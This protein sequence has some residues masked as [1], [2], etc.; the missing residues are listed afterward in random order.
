MNTNDYNGKPEIKSIPSAI[1]IAFE[2]NTQEW[3]SY[4]MT[5]DKNSNDVQELESQGYKALF[6]A[7]LSE[8]TIDSMSPEEKEKYKNNI[9]RAL[10]L[11][12]KDTCHS[13]EAIRAITTHYYSSCDGIITGIDYETNSLA[14]FPYGKI[15]ESCHQE[16]YNILI[17]LG[18]TAS[19]NG[20]QI[21]VESKTPCPCI[22]K[23]KFNQ[24]YE[25]FKDKAILAAQNIGLLRDTNTQARNNHSL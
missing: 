15:P 17:E 11:D 3:S 16:L 5:L 20:L 22:K 21:S 12:T 13:L 1:E 14:I 9:N 24:I 8:E 19:L 25:C 10:I 6:P 7:E 2:R 18:Y 23:S 4:S